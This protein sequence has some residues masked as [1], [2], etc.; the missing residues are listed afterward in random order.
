MQIKILAS[1]SMGVRSMATFVKTDDVSI[2]IDPSAALGP[3]RYGLPPHPL[4]EKELDKRLS[5]I[6][7]FAKRCE[8]IVIT[9]YHYDHYNPDAPEIFDGKIVYVKHPKDKINLSQR[10][11]A[12]EFL[13]LIKD[14]VDEMHYADASKDSF[15]STK[16]EFSKP[17]PHGPSSRLGY[18]VETIISCSTGKFLHT[19]DVEGPALDEQVEFIVRHKPDTVFLD[20]PLSYIMYRYGKKNLDAALSNMKKILM[21][22]N[23]LVVDHHF[24]RDAKCKEILTPVVEFAKKRNAVVEFASDFASEKFRP[25]EMQRKELYNTYGH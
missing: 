19:S 2:L 18:V 17:V 15:G 1:D 8:V 7:A 13:P 23:L 6:K 24:L 14:I 21:Y 4:E 12:A 20:G 5:S 3:S 11:R 22:S 16:V 25:L 9:H 10:K